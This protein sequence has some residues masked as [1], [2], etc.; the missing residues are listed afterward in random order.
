MC[1]RFDPELER[2]FLKEKPALALVAVAEI[3]PAYASLV[4]K[5]ID[6]TLSHTIR[7]LNQLESAGLIRTRFEGRVRHLELTE[8]GEKAAKALLDLR[9]SLAADPVDR[10][11]L[12]RIKDLAEAAGTDQ[13]RLGPLRRDLARMRASSDPAVREEA[14]AL[15]QEI[16]RKLLSSDN[17][18][19]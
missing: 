4:S 17:P 7:I 11:G 3:R 15:D 9:L 6:S 14:R 5:R 2:L 16:G 19:R 13:L 8:K 1:S 10:P 18:R 12:E